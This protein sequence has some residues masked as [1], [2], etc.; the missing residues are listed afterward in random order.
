[1]YSSTI[2]LTSALNVVGGQ[3]HAPAAFP[4]G[5]KNRYRMYRW[6]SG[7]QDR[8]GRWH[9]LGNAYPDRPDRGQSPHRLS[10]HGQQT[11]KRSAKWR[12]PGLLRSCWHVGGQY[13]LIVREVR[14]RI[15]NRGTSLPYQSTRRHIARDCHHHHHH[16][17]SF[18]ELGHLLTC[19]VSR[20]QKSLQRSTMIPSASWTVVFHYPGQ[21]ISRHSIYMLYP[22]SLV[23]Q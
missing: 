15:L 18:V 2:S 16:H 4:P 10:C 5:R 19:S 7:L 9:L 21:S 12:P 1:M 13:T 11:A 8:S 23:F 3:R 14:D 22:A 6:L 17:L 20:I